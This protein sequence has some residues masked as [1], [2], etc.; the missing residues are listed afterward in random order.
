MK[1]FYHFTFIIISVSCLT[2]LEAQY[3][4][5]CQERYQTEMEAASAA[6]NSCE[7]AKLTEKLAMCSLNCNEV[8]EKTKTTI[9]ELLLM[10]KIMKKMKPQVQEKLNRMIINDWEILTTNWKAT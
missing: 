10:G 7:Y 8:D 9:R 4:C 1:Y 3:L 2:Q 6:K 5:G